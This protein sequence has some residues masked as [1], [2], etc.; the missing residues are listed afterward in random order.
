MSSRPKK[1]VSDASALAKTA[2]LAVL[3]SRPRTRDD[4]FAV[5]RQ[6]SSRLHQSQPATHELLAAY[7]EMIADRPNL[8]ASR[9]ERMLVKARV[10]SLSGVAVVTVLTKP[11]HCPGR[12]IYCPSEA[13]M[14]K[15][16]LSNEPAAMRA[17]TYRFDPY[18][19]V[20]GRLRALTD[21]GHPTD[22]IELIVKGGTWSAHRWDYRRE[23]VRRC[24]DACN[25]FTA[26]RRRTSSDLATSQ[27]RNETAGQRIVGLTLETRPDFITPPE[28]VR[29]RELGCTR[30]EL[31]VQTTDD[32]ILTDCRRGHDSSAVIRATALLR[33]AGFKV[34][35]HLMP[36]LPGATPESDLRMLRGVFSSPDYRP[37]MIKI[38]PCAVLK[39]AE[40]YDWWKS[41]RYRPY[42]DA[43]LLETLIAIKKELPHYC[44]VSRVIRDIPS[45]SIVAGNSVTSL[46]Q[47]VEKEMKTRGLACRCLRCREI[48]RVA[49]S[50]PDILSAKPTLFDD[51][52]EASGGTEHFLS[53][54]DPERRAVFAFC[55]LRLP[56]NVSDQHNLPPEIRGAALLRELHTYGHLVPIDGH[57][58]KSAQH[59]GHGRRLMDEA[60]QLARQSGFKRMAV[61][62]GV[63]VRAYYRKL[64][65]RRRGTYM[66]KCL[67]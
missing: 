47:V 10:R 14:P 25:D 8:A 23:F 3:K 33:D 57:S 50:D 4:L 7:H 46:R 38:Y 45:P 66:I 18:N 9:I 2:I 28:I 11:Y 44:R 26:H 21:N 54:E 65:Y 53:F 60:E 67:N 62:S 48:G 15:S 30:I 35:Y 31:G 52:Y 42:S 34:D 43:G 19:Q 17:L 58:P 12:C 49:Q 64:G 29:L 41:G 5:V 37:D 63:G 40:L 56:G 39:T 22:K 32:K 1:P 20:I 27:R 16:Y 24:F 61:I 59:H 36:Q 13:R 55:R 6:T 51:I